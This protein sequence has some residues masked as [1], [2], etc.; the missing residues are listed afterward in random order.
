MITSPL[1][2]QTGPF[3]K[4]TLPNPPPLKE[5]YSREEL[6]TLKEEKAREEDRRMVDLIV[7]KKKE[8]IIHT[9]TYG[10][11]TSYFSDL[12][13]HLLSTPLERR[14]H[15]IEE[16]VQ[17]LKETFPGTTVEYK[18]QTCIR[19]GKEMNLGLYVDWT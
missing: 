16:V 1:T 13:N 3:D 11:S 6:R 4:V 19:T 10:S 8:A 18:S 14:D 17:K 12:R 2:A 5:V 15:I 9:A 7:R